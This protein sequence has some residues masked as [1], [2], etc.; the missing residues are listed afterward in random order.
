[1]AKIAFV[2]DRIPLIPLV[3]HSRC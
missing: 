2:W 3:A 1:M